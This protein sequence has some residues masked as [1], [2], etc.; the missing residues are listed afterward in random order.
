[1]AMP[2]RTSPLKKHDALSAVRTPDETVWGFRASDIYQGGENEPLQADGAVSAAF[3]SLDN[4]SQKNYLP[5]AAQSV[6]ARIKMQ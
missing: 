1:M 4:E 2:H 6:R 5:V 3:K